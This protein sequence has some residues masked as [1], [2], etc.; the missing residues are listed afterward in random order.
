MQRM[1]VGWFGDLSLNLC[2]V[3]M[4]KLVINKHNL[5]I[6]SMDAIHTSF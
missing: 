2:H 5:F 6:T 3:K 1:S 4:S